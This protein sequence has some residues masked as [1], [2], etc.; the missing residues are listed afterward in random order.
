M[1]MRKPVSTATARD[2]KGV[3]TNVLYVLADGDRP[4]SY[5]LPRNPNVPWAVRLWK[6]PVKWLGNIVFLGGILACFFHY[7]RY[8]PWTYEEQVPEEESTGSNDAND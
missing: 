3:K 1:A 4:E 2:Y 8:G 6:G 5:G 7:Q